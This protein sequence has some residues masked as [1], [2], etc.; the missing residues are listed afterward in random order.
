MSSL[1]DAFA[2]MRNLNYNTGE[3]QVRQLHDVLESLAFLNR[4]T[5]IPVGCTE[6]AIREEAWIEYFKNTS[7]SVRYVL[8][9][10]ILE[11]VSQ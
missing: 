6:S 10:L 11:E 2:G 7:G 5:S 8:Q 4:Q 3:S 1:H 9:G